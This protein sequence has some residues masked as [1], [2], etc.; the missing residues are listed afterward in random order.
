[1]PALDEIADQRTDLVDVLGRP[2]QV[3]DA[4][5]AESREAR[6]VV[7]RHRGGD[8]GDG[9]AAALRLRDQLVVDVGDVHDPGHVVPAVHQMA[10]DR[11][12][13]DGA[14]HVPD[15]TLPIHRRAA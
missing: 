11:V 3:V 5:H 4:V 12:E 10:L 2:R 13:D 9:H 7:V 14:N 6:Q 8:L 15:V 1:M